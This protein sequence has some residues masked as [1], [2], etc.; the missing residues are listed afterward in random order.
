MGRCW[1]GR[2]AERRL[3]RLTGP[4]VGRK[5]MVKVGRVGVLQAAG[6]FRKSEMAVR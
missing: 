3:T 5:W 1:G 6:A 2:R 4:S